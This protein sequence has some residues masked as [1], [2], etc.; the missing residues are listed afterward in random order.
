MKE[1]QQETVQRILG[2][3]TDVFAEVGFTGARMDEIAERAQVNK[4]TIYYHLGDKAVL[5]AEVLRRTIGRTAE[6]LLRELNSDST[7]EEKLKAYVRT[8]VQTIEKNPQLPRI[9]MR[10]I[11]SGV[12]NFPEV[13]AKNIAAAL[14]AIAGILQEG[15]K[16][17]VFEDVNPLFVH[18]M[19]MGCLLGYRNVQDIQKKH[20]AFPKSV[21]EL[22]KKRTADIASEIEKLILKAV[23]G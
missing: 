5:Y 4:A 1:K 16:A 3:A 22:G 23:K 17:G 15:I 7:P 19:V 12:E 20:P 2:A 9:I 10:E 11:A 18:M 8:I 13:L 21:L 14:G 6:L